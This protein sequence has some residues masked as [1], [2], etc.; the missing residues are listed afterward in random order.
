MN[1]P[2]AEFAPDSATLDELSA[3]I[4]NA[5]PYS[6]RSYGPVG[7]LG[8]V[9]TALTERCQGAR[10][11][12]TGL[13]VVNF[14]GDDNALYLFNGTS[15][16]DVTQS[17]TT[18][19]CAATD[20][21]AF[22]DFGNEVLAMNGT[23]AMQT[24][25]IGTSTKFD[26]RT[27]SAGSVPVSRYACVIKDFF[28]VA[29]IT[30]A[31]NRVQWPDIN[32]T[33]AW[34][35]GLA[36]SQDLPSGGQIVGIVGGEFGTIFSRNEIRT[37]TF[38]GAPDVF[39]FDVISNNRGCDIPGSIA[40]YQGS[41]F[42]HAPDG[43]W[44]LTGGA[45]TPIGAGKVDRWFNSRLDKSKLHLV[46]SIVDP[47]AKRYY[48]AYPTTQSGSGRNSEVLV[49]DFSFQRWA[50]IA[51]EVDELFGARLSLSTTLEGL[52]AAY[53]N[54]DTMPVSLDS[55]EFTGSEEQTLAVFKQS[56]KAALFG[57]TPM[58]AYIDTPETELY[59]PFQSFLQGIRPN[60]TGNSP[61]VSISVG[62]RND[63]AE[64]ITWGQYVTKNAQGRCPFRRQGRF[65]R[66][67]VKLEG[68]W[69][70]F[71]GVDPEAKK[72]GRR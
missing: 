61:T 14:A 64:S 54:L 5:L 50:P 39:Q 47:V 34:S 31:Q 38:I 42:F 66:A 21:W 56:K 17:A 11:F 24:W 30:G 46:R 65:H 29:N 6:Q 15:W 20:F 71:V 43:F 52:D 9:G 1:I 25:T 7:E 22:Q 62:T 53:P 2:P 49:Y 13:G 70:T 69:E 28:V 68:E 3:Y 41:I 58:D 8:E 18:Y 67:R 37:M 26:V 63:L 55:E 59:P 16:N 35:G 19:S 36:S 4:L 48:I 10:S 32:T 44:L 27:A 51:I 57:S 23:N 45:P 33:N 40:S 72:A 12:K 60:V